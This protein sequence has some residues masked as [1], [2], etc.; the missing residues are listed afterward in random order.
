MVM[1]NIHTSTFL[2]ANLSYAIRFFGTKNE[3]VES[4]NKAALI[5]LC[6]DSCDHDQNLISI[7]IKAFCHKMLSAVIM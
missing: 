7:D 1:T 6:V 3:V 5:Y 4:K 2:K